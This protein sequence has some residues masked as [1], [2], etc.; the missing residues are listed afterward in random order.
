MVTIAAEFPDQEPQVREFLNKK[1][2]S[3]KNYIFASGNK[4]ELSEALDPAW[5]G[6]L[7][8]T[9]IVDEKGNV[10]YRE[11]GSINFL[12]M[13]RAIVPALNRLTPWKGLS[14]IPPNPPKTASN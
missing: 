1:H 4:D 6:P 12:E 7:P 5:K 10:I 2:A 8:Y 13:R 9:I 3:T 14:P 11:M